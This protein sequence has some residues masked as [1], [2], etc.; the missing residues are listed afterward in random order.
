LI[1][2]RK[3]DF[4]AQQ[5]FEVVHYLLSWCVNPLPLF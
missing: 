5:L 1:A 4:Y 3:M 2:S